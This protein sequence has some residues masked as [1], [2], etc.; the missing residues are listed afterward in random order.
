MRAARIIAFGAI[1]LLSAVTGTWTR[2]A[3]LFPFEVV[4]L[5]PTTL[6][7]NGAVVGSLPKGTSCYVSGSQTCSVFLNVRS[8]RVASTRR[9]PCTPVNARPSGV[10]SGR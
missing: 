2:N 10:T 4:V 1:T 7:V 3:N 5:G 9:L 6:E 8:N